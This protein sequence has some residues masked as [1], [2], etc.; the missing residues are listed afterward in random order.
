MDTPAAAATGGLPSPAK[1]KPPSKAIPPGGKRPTAPPSNGPKVLSAGGGRRAEVPPRK[2]PAPLGAKAVVRKLPAERPEGGRKAPGPPTANAKSAPAKPERP[3]P[4]KSSRSTAPSTQSAIPGSSRPLAKTKPA[5]LPGS[6]SGA[7]PSPKIPIA[8]A[9]KRD[10]KV[11]L[12][13]PTPSKL[14]ASPA[15]TP[16][17]RPPPAPRPPPTPTSPKEKLKAKSPSRPG[18]N[19]LAASAPKKPPGAKTPRKETGKKPAPGEAGT[20]GAKTE[21]PGGIGETGNTGLEQDMP[22]TQGRG[23]DS[24][25]PLGPEPPADT[26][27]QPSPAPTQTL[28]P[29]REDG[30]EED[31]TPR[32][33]APADQEPD[34]PTEPLLAS[35]G[36]QTGAGSSGETGSTCLEQA[37][38]PT[39]LGDLQHDARMDG[40]QET[41][42]PSE[43]PTTA[44]Q[45]PVAAPLQPGAPAGGT[46]GPVAASPKP[47][48]LPL[49]L[50]R[51]PGKGSS[52]SPSST[53]SGP[54]LAGQSS[55][56]T[57]TPEELRA[58]DSSSGVE[59]KSDE[60]PPA[61]SPGPGEPD[62][63]IRRLPGSRGD[64]LKMS[65]EDSEGLGSGEAGTETPS[66]TPSPPLA[67]P[68]GA[69]IHWC[70]PHKI[71]EEETE[72]PGFGTGPRS[73]PTGFYSFTQQKQHRLQ[74]LP[75]AFP[76]EPKA[77]PLDT[78]DLCGQI[79]SCKKCVVDCEPE[80]EGQGGAVSIRPKRKVGLGR[81]GSPAPLT[82][83]PPSTKQ[84]GV[85]RPQGW[86]T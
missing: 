22:G 25:V 42:S 50:P 46:A 57:S 8:I 3:E 69:P 84:R 68:A 71:E 7:T 21:T 44:P 54:E 4:A 48:I 72:V 83:S 23:R 76:A 59:S 2:P 45:I 24:S 65:P 58:Y 49:G 14:A 10:T 55:S 30:V 64:L 9:T 33:P 19:I 6:Q 27:T 11:R 36:S 66:S 62:L 18:G 15:K 53:L 80:Q 52:S 67:P 75:P 40:L 32:A 17:P 41:L 51:S 26:Q 47:Q 29:V 37:I 78:A 70:C 82:S 77:E 73:L 34:G 5:A 1:A 86:K 35:L 39:L 61:P 31:K 28:P 20:R 81:T 85:L 63:S 74:L 43:H 60:R 56:E 12:V 16:R 13:A 38:S 79:Y